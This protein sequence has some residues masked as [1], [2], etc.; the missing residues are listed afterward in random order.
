MYDL[1]WAT[2]D[3]DFFRVIYVYKYFLVNDVCDWAYHSIISSGSYFDQKFSYT[4]NTIIQ[5]IGAQIFTIEMNAVLG[6]NSTLYGYTG[7]GTIW[8][9]E[10]YFGMNHPPGS[11][12]VAWPV[13][14]QSSELPPHHENTKF[15]DYFCEMYWKC[16]MTLPVLIGLSIGKSCASEFHAPIHPTPD[17]IKTRKVHERMK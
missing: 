7:L 6:H 8:T 5:V 17:A 10:M 2:L 1:F 13:N 3:Y 9:N 12:S 4:N 14:L 11:G 16:R 15:Y